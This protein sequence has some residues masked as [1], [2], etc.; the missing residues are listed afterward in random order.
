MTS[1]ELI[2]LIEQKVKNLSSLFVAV[3]FTNAVSE[4][5]R[6][7]GF[8]LPATN[9]EQIYWLDQ[10][11][12]RHLLFYLWT[13]TAI[14]FRVKQIHLNHKFDHLG[15]IIESM[16]KSWELAQEQLIG[17]DGMSAFGF[18]I[19]AGF[20]YDPATGRDTTYNKDQRIIFTPSSTDV[21]TEDS[22]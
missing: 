5:V 8:S 4:A 2:S 12:R 6:D 18:K 22:E 7:T 13:E 3:D 15:K 10:R 14:K 1:G 9:S 21:S 11:A 20:S 17:V 19:D 16:D